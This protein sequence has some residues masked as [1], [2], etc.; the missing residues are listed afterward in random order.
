MLYSA[1]NDPQAGNDPQTENDPQTANDPL[2]HMIP[3]PEKN[4]PIGP[5]MIPDRK[6]SANDPRRDPQLIPLE[7]GN[8]MEFG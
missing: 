5:Q 6:D 2:P 4:R 3:R 1:A 7:N 8:A